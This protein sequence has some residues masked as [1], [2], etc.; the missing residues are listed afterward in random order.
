MAELARLFDRAFG[1][2][3]WGYLTGLWHDIGEYS[4]EFHEQ[5][6]QMKELLK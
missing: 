6:E 1:A 2:G 4:E 5:T 3:D